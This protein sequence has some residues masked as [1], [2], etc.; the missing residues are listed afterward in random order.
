MRAMLHGYRRVDMEDEKTGRRISGFSCFVGYPVDGV[1]GQE[2]TKV[3]IS[4]NVCQASAFSPR[5]GEVELDTTP[6][7]KLTGAR[8]IS[9]K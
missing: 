2:V 7:G 6:K 8:M 3:F 9:A 4:D 1:E 5:L